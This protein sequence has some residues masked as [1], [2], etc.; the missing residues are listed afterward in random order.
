MKI[1]CHLP[2]NPRTAAARVE[3]RQIKYVGFFDILAN[4]AQ[5]RAYAL[6]A[7]A[8]MDYVCSALNRAGYEALIISASHTTARKSM[9]RATLTLRNG[10]TLK[11]FHSLPWGNLLQRLLSRAFSRASLFAYLVFNAHRG[12]PVLVYH[13]PA[14]I[15]PIRWAK[16]LKG[17]KIILEV[18]EIY[19][20]VQPLPRR[21][22][23]SEYAIFREADAFV[24]STEL[25]DSAVNVGERPRA[26]AYGSYGSVVCRRSNRGDGKIHVVYAGT[27]DPRKGGA[28][29]AAAAQFLDSGY[30]V[31][32][33][34]FGSETDTLELRNV[35]ARVAATSECALTYDGLLT[36]DAYDE[37]LSSC[38]IGLST[39]RSD[40]AFNETSF[41]SKVLSY[42]SHGLR[43]VS[44]DIPALTKTRLSDHITFYAGNDPES[45]AEAIRA[46][47]AS[48]GVDSRL[49]LEQLD[50]DFVDVISAMLRELS[51]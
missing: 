50:S 39:Q 13:S 33:L 36:G 3:T 15:G 35:I 10:V 26:I 38:D 37:F 17:F 25:L 46:A 1:H 6:S 43:V 34:G 23:R 24:L 19:Q 22:Q 18:E 2:P 51:E 8:K 47:D 40:A 12:E 16:K 11:L 29:A 45:I 48:S 5:R 4:S 41:P 28:A 27:F 49:L 32:V 7:T 30:H 20:D 44:V 9:R 31:H 42:M 14:L 21:L